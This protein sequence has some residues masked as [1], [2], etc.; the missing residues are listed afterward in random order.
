M[1]DPEQLRALSRLR[2]TLEAF[3][4]AHWRSAADRSGTIRRLRRM[5]GRLRE[6]ATRGD[7]AAFHA[8]DTALHRMAVESARL[9]ALLRSWDLVVAE[10]EEWIGRLQREY[11]PSLMALYREHVFLLDS[12][13]SPDD[14]MAE[15]ATHQHLEAGWHR[16]AAA[17]GDVR[18]EID[19]VGRATAFMSTHFAN[20]LEMGWIAR[21]VSFVSA[22]HLTR[23]FRAKLGISPHQFLRRVRLDR[24]AQLL[25]SGGDAVAVIGARVGYRNASH[26]VRNFRAEFGVTPLA[27][28]RN[29][30][31]RSRR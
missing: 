26:F 24:A 31:S 21:H 6:A 19:P 20:R 8:V 25:R 27:Y 9:P 4:V 5:L 17:R 7:Y 22:V 23:L 3:A 13:C 15:N 30:P 11:W 1:I 16:V 28:R 18:P 2:S 10:L 12:W 29:V 14:W